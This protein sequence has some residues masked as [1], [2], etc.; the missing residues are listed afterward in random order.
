M[1][2][3]LKIAMLELKK[4]KPDNLAGLHFFFF[5]LKHNCFHPAYPLSSIKAVHQIIRNNCQLDQSP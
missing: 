4:R 1:R 5:S 3:A 2:H